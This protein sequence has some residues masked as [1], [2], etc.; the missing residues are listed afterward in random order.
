MFIFS[1]SI[2]RLCNRRKSSLNTATA[3]DQ[4]LNVGVNINPDHIGA[5][6]KD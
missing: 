3:F 4:P 6:K 2:R 1:L 5:L